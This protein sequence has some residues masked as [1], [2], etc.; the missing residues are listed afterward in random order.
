VYPEGTRSRDGKLHKG[1]PGPARLAS[2]TGAPIVP[3]GLIGTENVQ[4]PGERLPHVFRRVTVRFGSARHVDK[5]TSHLRE[6][7][8]DLMHDIADLCGQTYEG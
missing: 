7:T 5:G 4:L 1:N 2:R 3:V 8:D 6:A